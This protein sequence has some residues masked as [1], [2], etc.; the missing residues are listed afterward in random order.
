MR[1]FL[2]LISLAFIAW[3]VALSLSKAPFGEDKIVV[4][5]HY[6]EKGTEE[7][8]AANIVT[9]VVVIYRGFDTLG[10][11]TVLFIA[12]L[13]LGAVLYTRRRSSERIEPSSLVLRTGC[14]FLFPL[15]LLFGAYIFIHGH[16]TPGGGFQGGAIVASGFLLIYLGC[17]ERRTQEL[18]L[19]ATESLGGLAFVVLGLVGLAVGGYFLTNFL[20]KGTFNS[21]ISAGVIPLIYVAIGFKV[22]SELA[23]IMGNLMERTK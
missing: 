20:P 17:P 9:S 10:E 15:I 5:K 22:G 8:G 7:T 11:V 13:G 23:G 1:K 21:L 6:L 14:R 16:L 12:A 3:G 2:A 19:G 18:R 4:G